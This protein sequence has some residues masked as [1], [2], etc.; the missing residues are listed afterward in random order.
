ML[1]YFVAGNVWAILAVALTVGRKAWR[2]Q[3]ARYEFFG[4]GSLDPTG[5][6]LII[7]FC[8]TATAIFFLLAWKT[9]GKHHPKERT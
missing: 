6:N 5:Y 2:T 7:A 4:Y 9:H 3:P 8:V 1:R